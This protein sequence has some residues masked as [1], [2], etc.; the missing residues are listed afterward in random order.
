MKRKMLSTQV[1]AAALIGMI[2]APVLHAADEAFN[3]SIRIVAALAISETS[4]LTF[5]QTEASTSTQQV[6]IGPNDSGAASFN[7]TGEPNA[8]VT[9]SIVEPSLE[10]TVG[11]TTITINT[12]TFG[13]ALASN[14]SVSLN[15]SGS[16]TGAKVGATANIP[17]NPESGQYSGALTFRVVY[18]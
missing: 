8:G 12:F 15:G 13:G 9:A 6:A 5:P 17:A 3:A 11:Q 2:S 7:I 4:A 10:M 1:V 14:G 18:N 16:A